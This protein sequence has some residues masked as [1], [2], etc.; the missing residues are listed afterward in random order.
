MYTWKSV[1]VV[2]DEGAKASYYKFTAPQ[3]VA[4]LGSKYIPTVY[5]VY[6]S[7]KGTFDFT[8]LLRKLSTETRGMY[9][10]YCNP[11]KTDRKANSAVTVL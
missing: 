1:Y 2:L 9:S 6:N 8:T 4:L 7:E 3:L 11:N 10:M 5:T